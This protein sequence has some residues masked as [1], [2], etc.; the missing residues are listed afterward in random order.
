MDGNK[1][2]KEDEPRMHADNLNSGDMFGGYLRFHQSPITNH[3]SRI[4]F[5]FLPMTGVVRFSP[6]VLR[7][8]SEILLLVALCLRVLCDLSVL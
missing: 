7:G 3:E 2:E 8:S 5:H 1:H 6:S 4:T